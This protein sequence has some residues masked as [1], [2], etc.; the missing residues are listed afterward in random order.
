MVLFL[1][2]GEENSVYFPHYS[3]PWCIAMRFKLQMF[4]VHL[5]V[6]FARNFQLFN[7]NYFVVLAQKRKK[8][9]LKH[10][11]REKSFIAKKKNNL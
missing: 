5:N 9:N 11:L 4:I 2:Y 8:R 6:F 7:L 10:Q 1:F 3:F